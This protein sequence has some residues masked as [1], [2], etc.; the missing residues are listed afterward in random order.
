MDCCVIVGAKV[1]LV[2]SLPCMSVKRRRRGGEGGGG[3]EEEGEGG[4]D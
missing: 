2:P 1:F 3:V 4:E